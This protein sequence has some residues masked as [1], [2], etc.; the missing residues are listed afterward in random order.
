MSKKYRAHDVDC[1]KREDGTILLKARA[2]LGPVADRTTDWLDDWANRTPEAVFLAERSGEG[3]REVTYSQA[4]D[5]ARAIAAGLLELGL[6]ASTPILILSGNSVDH[7]LLCL[8]AQYVG[9]PVVPIAEQYALIPPARTQID[10]IA[11][12]VKPGMVFAEDGDMLA[13][14]LDREVF[15]SI[16]KLASR[17]GPKGTHQLEELAR[18]GGDISAAHDLV[19]PQ[20]IAKILMTSGSTS[21][22]KGV[23]TSHRMMCVN[24]TQIAYGLPFLSERPPLILDWLPWNHVFGGSHNFNMMLANGGALYVDGGKPTPQLIGRTLENMRMKAGTMSFNVPAGFAMVRD[25]LRKDADLR[26]RYFE[27]LDMLF[28]AGASLPQGVWSDL[29]DMAREVRGDVP[30]FTS[31]WGLTET[32][33]AVLLQTQPI[34]QSGVIGIPLPGQEVKLLPDEDMR[35]EVRVRGPN[36]FVGYL[37]N[38]EVTAEVFDEEGFFKTGDAMVFVDPEE[39]NKGLKFDGRISEEFKLQTGTWVRAAALRLMV[40]GAL[41]DCASDVVITGADRSE[42]GLFIIPSAATAGAGDARVVEGALIVQSVAE[43]IRS[44]L[45]E[46]GSSSSTRIARA[47]ILAEPPSIGEGEITAKGSLN[48]RRILTR[49]ADLLARLYT[50]TDQAVIRFT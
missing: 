28:Y 35:C 2:T 32:A 29:E 45:A 17:G 16:E 3:W 37:D 15:D 19:G 38:P 36:I 33:P 43:V 41:G 7:G 31:S 46:I 23:P 24:Q 6:D 34:D 21:A 20:T 42:I 8:A 22:P 1:E 39:P 48:S 4:K 26:R 30:L 44:R 5:K 11:R 13:E 40:L 47:I 14:V 18:R 10:F 27:E 49:R 12:L 9:I 50:D 25:E